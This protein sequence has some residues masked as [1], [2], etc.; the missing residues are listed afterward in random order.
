MG[1]DTNDYTYCD[2]RPLEDLLAPTATFIPRP[3]FMSRTIGVLI[4]TSV[5]T[6]DPR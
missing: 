1:T 3:G 5:N 2:G 4:G 6:H